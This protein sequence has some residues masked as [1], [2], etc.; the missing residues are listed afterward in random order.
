MKFALLATTTAALKISSTAKVEE[1]GPSCQRIANAV[2]HHCDGNGDGQITWA[3]ASHCGAPAQFRPQFDAAAGT[4]GH[5][6]RGEFL[7]ACRAHGGEA[8]VEEEGAP[9]GRIANHIY[10]AC[11]SNSDGSLTWAEARGCGAPRRFRPQFEAAA[12]S[13]HELS[14]AE[15]VSAC[16]A[17]Q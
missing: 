5:L 17:H 4:D 3:E 8:E 14:R 10:R 13:D 6:S 1:E 9:C 11:D 16:R 2:W 12:G 15:F 7:T